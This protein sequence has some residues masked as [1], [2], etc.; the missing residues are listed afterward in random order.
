M[1]NLI[2]NLAKAGNLRKVFASLLLITI[3]AVAIFTLLPQNSGTDAR[4]SVIGLP[5]ANSDF[6]RA[7]G[8][9]QMSFPADFGPHP[10]YQTE[11]W[12]YTG[13]LIT[14]EGRHFGYQLTFFRRSIL[15]P[16]ELVVRSSSWAM[17]Q[18]Y[19]AHFALTDAEGSH[20]YAFEQFARGSAGL[21]GAQSTP[22]FQ[23]W[24]YDWQVIQTGDKSFQLKA[25]RGGVA[26]DLVLNDVKGTILEGDRGYS[27]KGPDPGNASYYFSQTR[28]ATHGEI[29]INQQS[30]K[31]SGLSWMDHEFSTSALAPEQTGWDWFALQMSDGSELMMYTIRDKDGSID[32]YSSGTYIAPDGSTTWLKQNEFKIEVSAKWRSP[33]TNANY[34][35]HWT[36]TIPTLDIK[37][38]IAPFLADQELR[39]SFTYWEGAVHFTG[40]HAGQAVTGEGYIEMT[41]YAQSIQ[42]QF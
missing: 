19:M 1:N 36:V 39:L 4:A 12:Y 6:K 7:D 37:L 11:W 31:V 15:T 41:G 35:A 40:Q 42:G 25:S 21:A 5:P 32:P 30:F 10:D 16:D 26:V 29:Q 17:N 14:P 22:V 13:H 8:P 2:K 24:L 23:V 3:T 9:R 18:V 20:F 38:D 28:L 33:A 27:Q 34:P